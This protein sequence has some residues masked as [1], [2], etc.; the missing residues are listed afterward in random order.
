MVNSCLHFQKESEQDNGHFSVLGS[1]KKWYSISED[2]PTRW[3]GRNGWIDEKLSIHYYAD[4]ET[5]SSTRFLHFQKESEQDNGHF[6]VLGQRRSGI[7]SVKIVHK[8]N[9]TKW[10]NWWKIVDPL[11][12]R[13]GN[14][15]N[16]FSHNYLLI[17]CIYGAVSDLCEECETCHVGTGRLVVAGQSGSEGNTKIGPRIGSYNLLPARYIRSGDQN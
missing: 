12:R 13:P 7:L 1:E 2:S 3:M 6:S 4:Q 15:W 17:I 11:L 14:D 9:G 5:Q 16:Y 10:L 8:V